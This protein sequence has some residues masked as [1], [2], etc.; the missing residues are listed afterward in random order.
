[1][2]KIFASLLSMA[3]LVTMISTVS[4]AEIKD[5]YNEQSEAG[6]LAHMRA[7]QNAVTAHR[8]LYDS[9]SIDMDGTVS[10]PANYGGDYIVDDILHICI[11]DITNQDLTPYLILL[12]DYLE[13]IVFEDVTFSISDLISFAEE[14]AT[15]LIDDGIS[16]VSWGI[17]ETK[18]AVIID[19]EQTDGTEISF[20]ASN[21]YQN[22]YSVVRDSNEYNIP[23]QFYVRERTKA[24]VDLMG[25]SKLDGY[26]LGIC[27]TYDGKPAFAMCGHGLT[28][29]GQSMYYQPL[30]RLIGK[31]AVCQF[32]NGQAGDYAIVNVSNSSFTLTSLLGDPN[33]LESQSSAKYT[34]NRPAVGTDVIK[35][36][37]NGGFAYG[38]VSRSNTSWTPSDG[39]GI[40]VKGLVEV[41]LRSGV[42]VSGDSGGPILSSDGSG[43]TFYGTVSSASSANSPAYFYFSPYEYLYSSGFRAKLG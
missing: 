4:G 8:I 27:G 5:I 37:K 7:Q 12:S 25:G 28:G 11:V 2:K 26:T 42:S 24:S 9:F 23:V 35:Y 18:N 19:L 10:Y 6:F 30:N 14:I 22:N 40:T 15:D 20:Y 17:S 41:K 34:C 1:M 29:V 13:N 43:S 3:I 33:D 38:T 31:V 36:G 39:S 32:A 16:V 21:G